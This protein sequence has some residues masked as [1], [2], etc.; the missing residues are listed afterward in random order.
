MS[1]FDEQSY[2]KP[3]DIGVYRALLPFLKRYTKPA[4][5]LAGA[6]V[7]ASGIDMAVPLFLRYAIDRFIGQN[8]FGGIVPYS[9]LYFSV[10]ALQVLAAL[11][12]AQMAMR[13]ELR[14][15]R[16]LKRALFVHLQTLSFSYYNATPVGYAHSRVMSDTG[17]IAGLLSWGI[18]EGVWSS[19]YAI[20]VMIIM[21]GMNWK[22]A[23]LVLLIVPAV[24][25]LTFLFRKKMLGAHRDIRKANSQITRSYNESIGGA[26]TSKVLVIEEQNYRT[27][28]GLTQ[29]YYQSSMRASILQSSFMPLVAFSGSL[30]VA[31]ILMRGGRLA[32][33]DLLNLGTL[34]AFITYATGIFDPV[35]NLANLITEL[36]SLQACVERVADLLHQKPDICDSEPVLKQYGD[37]FAPLREN[38]EALAGEVEFRDVTFRYPDGDEDVLEHFHLTVPK[39]TTVAIVGETGA[40]KSTIV[41]LACR[42]FEPVGGEILIDGKDYRERSQLWLH[43]NIGYVLQNPHLFS[44]SLADN[45]RYGKLDATDEEVRAAAAL[46]S[47]DRVA[48]RLEKGYDTDVGESGD[49]LSTGEKQ[50][51]SYA[52]AL[53]A[54]PPIFILDEATSS[55]DTETERLIQ[56]ATST[57]LRGRTSFIIAHRLSTIKMADIILVVKD[58][59]IVERGSHSELMQLHGSYHSLYTRQFEEDAW[60]K[61]GPC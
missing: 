50:L 20:G 22:M 36:I 3:F 61:N 27:F 14:L 60:L 46:V 7:L 53:I 24:A 13:I 44:G 23:L 5:V 37:S 28:Q 31:L 49:L 17:R 57:L 34:T 15:G 59:K 25:V 19:T 35:Q 54:N 41:N 55:V 30:A 4:L 33:L 2:D 10:I 32:M 47:A 16:D 40:G 56:E 58:G 52:R 18:L 42:F 29:N 12:F 11:L 21:F 51:V 8:S 39:G 9:A 6:S 43:S 26:R 48:E 38:W 45:I 1:Q